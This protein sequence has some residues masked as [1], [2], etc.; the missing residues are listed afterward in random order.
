VVA[1]AVRVVVEVVAGV[2]VA[3]AGAVEVTGIQAKE[4]MMKQKNPLTP[5]NGLIAL[6][7]PRDDGQ[8]WRVDHYS[9]FGKY[10]GGLIAV[11]YKS[12]MTKREA[13]REARRSRAW[14]E[15]PD[16]RHEAKQRRT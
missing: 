5:R 14:W 8:G 15:K 6:A 9:A 3:V 12:T 11:N 13:Q 16:R 10:S 1:V 2:A 7:R 4:N